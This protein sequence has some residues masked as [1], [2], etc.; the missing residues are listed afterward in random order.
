M[1]SGWLDVNNSTANL[2]PQN[3]C[4]LYCSDS[5]SHK[6][7]RHAQISHLTVSTVSVCSCICFCFKMS[8][9]N[10]NP[11]MTEF[12]HIFSVGA[13]IAVY[14]HKCKYFSWNNQKKVEL[15]QY[16]NPGFPVSLKPIF[17]NCVLETYLFMVAPVYLI[18]TS[19]CVKPC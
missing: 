15:M 8:N 9:L 13:F 12:C 2:V 19:C 6:E 16:Y 17:K 3:W 4:A 5:K 7:G 18:H 11:D 14:V 10:I 1:R